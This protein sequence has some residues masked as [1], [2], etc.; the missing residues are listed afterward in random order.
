[1]EAKPCKIALSDLVICLLLT[2]LIITGCGSPTEIILDPEDNG[3][4]VE[5]NMGQV[6]VISLES[7]PSTG[8][9]WEVLEIDESILQQVGEVE[10]APADQREP[11]PLGVG[12]VEVFRFK[13]VKTGQANLELVYYRPWEEGVEPLERYAIQ[14]VAK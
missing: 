4:R 7:N 10:F 13:I 12:G 14:V 5:A 9:R 2:T 11:P 8:Y 3:S 6:V 1:M